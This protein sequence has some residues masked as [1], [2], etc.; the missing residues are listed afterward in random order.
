MVRNV[1]KNSSASSA[2]AWNSSA[3]PSW[4]PSTTICSPKTIYVDHPFDRYGWWTL[5]NDHKIPA[6]LSWMQIRWWMKRGSL[7]SF[8]CYQQENVLSWLP[9]S[10]RSKSFHHHFDIFEYLTLSLRLFFFSCNHGL[11]MFRRLVVDRSSYLASRWF[12]YGAPWAGESHPAWA[13]NLWSVIRKAEVVGICKKV[14]Y[15]VSLE[16][17]S[18]RIGL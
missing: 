5:S 6:N 10:G 15:E 14:S 2:T 1:A 4:R 7:W 18:G 11:F 8:F 17:P 16:N 13:V 3:L 12:P 9:K